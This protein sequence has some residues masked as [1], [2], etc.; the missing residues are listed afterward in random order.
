MLLDDWKS[1]RIVIHGQIIGNHTWKVVLNSL[2][3]LSVIEKPV[4]FE[5]Y[6]YEQKKLEQMTSRREGN[7]CPR[8]CTCDVEKMYIMPACAPAHEYICK[9]LDYAIHY[10]VGP[11]ER[12]QFEDALN[13]LETMVEKPK[14]IRIDDEY[15]DEF[16]IATNKVGVD[17]IPAEVW[18]AIG[19]AIGFLL[20]NN[21]EDELRGN[22][23]KDFGFTGD[24]N[25]TR[26]KSNL[27]MRGLSAPNLHGGTMEYPWV[28]ILF[29]FLS[30]RLIKLANEN[31]FLDDLY[32]HEQ[33]LERDKL[34]HSLF[35]SQIHK[36]NYLDSMR[37]ALNKEDVCTKDHGDV[38]NDASDPRYAA[39]GAVSIQVL[40]NNERYRFVKVGYMKR[41]VASCIDRIEKHGPLI[42]DVVD[43]YRQHAK[44]EPSNTDVENVIIPNTDKSPEKRCFNPCLDKFAT[45]YSGFASGA[46]LILN[47]YYGN[48]GFS[49]KLKF[50]CA[51]T[52]AT[53][54]SNYPEDY[55]YLCKAISQDE[56]FLSQFVSSTPT[57][58]KKQ[59]EINEGR[60]LVSEMSPVELLSY[61]TAALWKIKSSDKDGQQARKCINP[62][63]NNRTARM[64]PAVNNLPS[65]QALERSYDLLQT[66]SWMLRFFR[67]KG[68]NIGADKDV[69]YLYEMMTGFLSHG[70]KDYKGG[71]YGCGDLTSQHLIGVG[72]ILNIFENRIA[73]HAEVPKSTLVATFLYETYHYGFHSHEEDM[74][75]LLI[76]IVYLLQEDDLHFNAV[77]AEELLCRFVKWK[78]I[79]QRI[80]V[81]KEEEAFSRYKDTVCKGQDLFR[82]ETI[83]DQ[84]G[85]K[86]SCI[87]RYSYTKNNNRVTQQ[88]FD[89]FLHWP[90]VPEPSLLQ[91][92]LPKPD[93]FWSGKNLRKPKKVASKRARKRGKVN[94]FCQRFRDYFPPMR[95]GKRLRCTDVNPTDIPI[96]D[97]PL[98][99]KAPLDSFTGKGEAEQIDLTHILKT[100]FGVPNQKDKNVFHFESVQV[101]S[102]PY[103]MWAAGFKAFCKNDEIHDIDPLY[104]DPNFC[105][106]ATEPEEVKE[107][108][109]VCFQ[110]KRYFC[111]KGEAKT[112][113]ALYYLLTYPATCQR[114][115]GKMAQLFYNF[116]CQN[117]E[118][119]E[120]DNETEAIQDLTS[121]ASPTTKKYSR[122]NITGNSREMNNVDWA[123]IK[124]IFTDDPSEYHG[125]LSTVKRQRRKQGERASK[126]NIIPTNVDV[127]YINHLRCY[128]KKT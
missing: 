23:S 74:R 100:V 60:F 29:C 81:V 55:W 5:N 21:K 110:G 33:K 123:A 102:A 1:H 80:E 118:D 17:E 20:D 107:H 120:Y 125:K 8:W 39:S 114:L 3:I 68:F 76:A 86:E 41:A 61:L 73:C 117:E 116:S 115:G 106:Y 50:A 126:D 91:R 49:D 15:K 112:Y 111:S 32:G 95:G 99:I 103:P 128:Q 119:G 54:Y 121:Y 78:K 42:D 66:L 35:A 94:W 36:E 7:P 87:M 105:L 75:D 59:L 27:E 12:L 104:P 11:S 124:D 57:D 72:V 97:D 26:S 24:V 70:T 58:Y 67:P 62:E 45:L 64:Q 38:Q 40:V 89:G 52:I 96:C 25:H 71:V 37:I 9:R 98:F 16:M 47:T 108:N 18:D 90:C 84:K 85:K 83:S 10:Q 113:F 44:L 79:S 92:H 4:S 22:I 63:P 6:K 109:S 82:L 46:L 13:K 14:V 65:K 31:N 101:K 43:F 19:Q 51:V 48:L 127:T 69:R 56:Y 34:R 122:L 28:K 30:K 2:R 77:K 88:S 93:D 53:N